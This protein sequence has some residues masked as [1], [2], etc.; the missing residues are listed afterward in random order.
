MKG[1]EGDVTG[2]ATIEAA[3]VN[4]REQ[5]AREA[6]IGRATLDEIDDRHCD[7]DHRVAHR[8]LMDR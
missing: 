6:D 5:L 8:P 1:S 7:L 2:D 4:Y 3:I